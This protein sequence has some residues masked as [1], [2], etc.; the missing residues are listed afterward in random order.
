MLEEVPKGDNLVLGVMR[1]V[2]DDEIQ[3]LHDIFFLQHTLQVAD[4]PLVPCEPRLEVLVPVILLE[5]VHHT[6]GEVLQPHLVRKAQIVPDFE[7]F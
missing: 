5:E 3:P 1:A 6:Q 7:H 4:L 2:V